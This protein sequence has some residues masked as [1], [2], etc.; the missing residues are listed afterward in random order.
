MT[1]DEHQKQQ[2]ANWIKDGLKL[3]EIQNRLASEMG[4]T[5]TY[6]EVRLLVD[7]LKLVPKDPDPPETPDVPAPE[8]DGLLEPEEPKKDEVVDAPGSA[9]QAG[10]SVTVDTL[11]KPGS[12]VSG[13][14]TF[15]DGNQ[16][17][18]YLDQMGRLGL[19]PKTEGY[20]PSAADVQAFQAA[21]EREVRRAGL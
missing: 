1:L 10:V 3:A 6:M 14:V 13:N 17:E 15:S 16:A 12:L 20:R 5:L 2:V 7:D 11:T 19:V 21:L 9:A 4:I 18:W 8:T